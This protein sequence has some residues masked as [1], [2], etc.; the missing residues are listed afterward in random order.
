MLSKRYFWPLLLAALLL[1]PAAPTFAS[2]KSHHHH[3]KIRVGFP[4]L[5]YGHYG[6]YFGHRAYLGFY[7]YG[8]WHHGYYRHWNR[9]SARFGALDLNVKPK[10]TQVWIDGGYVGTTGKLD[11]TPSYLWLERDSYEVVF[12]KEGHESVVKRFTVTPGAVIKVDFD[13]APGTARSPEELW[14]RP[15]KAERDAA[16]EESTAER[17]A[18]RD[19]ERY[20]RDVGRTTPQTPSATVDAREEPA[21]VQLQMT[22]DDASVYLDGSFVGTVEQLER[23]GLLVDPGKHTLQVVHPDHESREIHLDVKPGETLDVES[24]LVKKARADV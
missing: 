18:R 8:G 16:A 23:G 9:G 17:D 14:T 10:D 2:G 5:Y 6:P 12:Y 13:M 19:A 22:P 7:P 3:H 11:G 4:S 1:L 21:R 15:T 24:Q 20:A